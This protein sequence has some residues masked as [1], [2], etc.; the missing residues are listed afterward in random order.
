MRGVIRKAFADIR[1]RPLQTALLFLVIAAAAATFSLALNV[2]SSASKPYGRLHERANGADFWITTW[3]DNADPRATFDRMVGVEAISG[4]NPISWTN[5]GI[6]NGDKKQQFALVGMG[7]ELPEF[8][9]PVVIR[10]RWIAA[11][12]EIVIDSGA[13]QVL[14]L[15]VGQRVEL[16]APSGLF[17]F[18]VVGFAA[19]ASREPAPINDPAFAY[20]FPENL[21]RIEPGVA[22]GSDPQH[23]LRA[24]I[25]TTTGELTVDPLAGRN[26][27]KIGYRPASDVRET[28]KQAN[29]FDVIFLNVFS[30]FAL[31]AVGLII[32]NTVAGQVLSQLRDTG[33]L[34]AIGFTPRQVMLSLM[35]QNLGVAVLAG[36]VGMVAGLLASR[37]FLSKTADVLGVPPAPAFNPVILIVT[38][39][40]VL[41]LVAFFTLIPAFRAGRVPAMVALRSSQEGQ[42]TRPS[43]VAAVLARLGLPRVGVVGVKDL[44][45]R[46]V[47]TATTIA[48]LVLAVITATF[49]LGIEATFQKTMSDPTTIGGPPYDLTIDRDTLDNA[50]ARQ[51][52]DSTPGV[53]SYL[54]L[55]DSSARIGHNGFDLRGVEG[56]MNNPRWAM[57][58]G[59][60]P[61]ARGEASV[62]TRVAGDFGLQV[63]DRVTILTG[64]I[65]N[66]TQ[67]DLT[68]VGTYV[69][70]DGE[71]MVVTHDTL[72]EGVEVTDYFIRAKPGTDS[73][74]LAQ[75]LVAAS[76]GVFDVEVL[77]DSMDE[78]RD[79]FRSVLIP[80]N[81][82]LFVIAGLNLLASLLLA[83]RERRR[84]FAVLKTVGFTPGQIAMSVFSGS[85]VLALL[86]LVI[87]LPLGLVIARVVFDLLSSAAGIGTGVGVMP[88][89]LWMAPLSAGAILIAALATVL[90]ALRASQVRVAEA[91]RYE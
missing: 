13:A 60:Q 75:S 11:A 9:H 87:G 74:E 43:L 46:P 24:G 21:Q 3:G 69:D 84:D 88:G 12:D 70:I 7:P 29:T 80:L 83:I 17:P 15:K 79:Q 6:R 38:M 2:A 4:P 58:Q 72:P 76:G 1:S 42:K 33:I 90:P 57:R 22:F 49:S 54:V 48:A 71:R 85:V 44:S 34:K 52:F 50:R 91:L 81:A 19:T 20:L 68:I 64:P 35:L 32:A 40:V 28:M 31:L 51:I 62:S 16:Q 67:L 23:V 59:R 86:A 45:R 61:T 65:E 66:E 36:V 8:D 14:K 77:D 18:T 25:R 55:Q 82:V 26:A 37:F 39:L 73:D 10:G 63:G 41:V 78:V 5:F 47:R 30:V 53:E 27:G 56:D 89:P